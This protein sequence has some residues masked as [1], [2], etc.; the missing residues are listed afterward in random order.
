MTVPA[1]QME[2]EGLKSHYMPLRGVLEHVLQ[3][4]EVLA[5]LQG[6]EVP[7]VRDA[8]SYVAPE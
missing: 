7:T 8:C 6:P 5:N 3:R 1:L 2:H 4:E